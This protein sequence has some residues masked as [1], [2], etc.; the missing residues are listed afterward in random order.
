MLQEKL[1][2]QGLRLKW[3][4]AL[5]WVECKENEADCFVLSILIQFIIFSV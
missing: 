5:E 4:E 3:Y 1:P 2:G